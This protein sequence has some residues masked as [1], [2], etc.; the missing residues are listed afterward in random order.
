M[1]TVLTYTTFTKPRAYDLG[2]NPLNISLNTKNVLEF[3]M[4]YADFEYMDV[5]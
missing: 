4:V 3:I 1:L 5:T 2:F